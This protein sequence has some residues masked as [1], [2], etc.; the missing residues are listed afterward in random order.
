M[1]IENIKK[2][3]KSIEAIG[4]SDAGM[5]RLAFT[6]SELEAKL[7]FKNIAEDLGMTVYFDNIG[8]VIARRAGREDTLSPIMIGS[9]IDTV[10]DGGA[11]DGAV[12]VVVGLEIIRRLNDKNVITERPIEIIAFTAEESSRFGISTI[13]SRFFTGALQSEEFENIV[14]KDGIDFKAA[15]SSVD[16]DYDLVFKS[17]N[18]VPDVHSYYE[19]HIEQGPIL[20]NK[21]LEVGIVTG[22]AA[23]TRLKLNY[24]GKASHSGATPMNMRRDAY[25]ASCELALFLESMAINEKKYNSVATVGS[26][27]VYPGAMNIVPGRVEQLIDIRSID[28]ETKKDLYKHVLKKIREIELNRQIEIRVELLS[29]EIP[30]QLDGSLIDSLEKICIE[31][32]KSFIKMPSGAGHDAMHMAKICPTNLLFIPCKEG[33]SHHKDEFAKYEDIENA[34]DVLE[35]QLLKNELQ[36]V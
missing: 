24:H 6:E 5:N 3:F 33:L 26:N 32:S 36:I 34:C 2:I 9:H 21:Q 14:D 35:L 23:P 4:Q 31:A 16:I 28:Y 13:G 29:N 8:N 25:L 10:Y 1:S 17:V 19:V 22:I 18:T 20:E 12:G 7:V 15:L 30:V 11:Y 27:V